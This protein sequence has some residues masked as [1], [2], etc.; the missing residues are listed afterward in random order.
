[1]SS[2]HEDK[3]DYGSV[4]CKWEKFKTANVT[5]QCVIRDTKGWFRDVEVKVEI[6]LGFIIAKLLDSYVTYPSLHVLV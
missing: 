5:L 3:G 1:M 2:D 4:V 6:K